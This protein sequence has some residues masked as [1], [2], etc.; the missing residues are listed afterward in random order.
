MF[1][2]VD[3]YSYYAYHE[4][5]YIVTVLA[6]AKTE[7]EICEYAKKINSNKEYAKYFGYCHCVLV[8]KTDDLIPPYKFLEMKSWKCFSELLH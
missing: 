4:R 7:K 3:E 2:I 6:M 8:Y 5:E 1:Y